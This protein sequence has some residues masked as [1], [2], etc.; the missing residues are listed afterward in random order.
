METFKPSDSYVRLATAC[1]EV[2]VAD[3]EANARAIADLYSQA[4]NQGAA[5]VVFPELSIT[6]YSL[7]DLVQQ[8]SLLQQAQLGLLDLAIKSKQTST[9]MVVGTPMRVGSGLYNCAVVIAEGELKG[10]VPKQN[11]PSYGEFYEKRWYKTWDQVTTTVTIGDKEVPFGTD[12]LFD[13]GAVRMGVEI[14]EDLW[15]LN[16]PHIDQVNNGALIIANPS[17]SPELVAKA[18]YRRDLVRID[19]AKMIGAYVYAGCDWTESTTDVVMSGHQI[20]AANG[21]IAAE[22]KPF[23]SENRVIVAD[24]DIDHLRHDR[25]RDTNFVNKLGGTVIRATVSQPEIEPEPDINPHPFLPGGE[26]DKQQAERLQSVID[27]QAHGL[28]RRIKQKSLRKLHLGLSGGLD[29]TLAFLVGVRAAQ[30]VGCEPKDVLQT[31]TMPGKAS[32]DRTQNNAVKLA[33]LYGISNEVIPIGDLSNQMLEAI[34]HTG[35]QDTTFENAQA[36]T[37]TTILYNKANQ[38]GGIVLGTGDLSEIALGWCT[39]NADQSS[40]YH[41]NAGVPKTLVRHLVQHVVTT[42]S[43]ESVKATLQDIVDTPVSPELVSANEGEISQKTEDIIGPYELHDFFMYQLI[44]WGDTPTKVEYLA[45]KAFEDTYTS[46]DISRWLKVFTKRFI[47]NQFKRSM[48]PDG[49]KVGSVALS[50][51]GDWRMPSDLYNAA[52]WEQA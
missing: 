49:V 5:L 9:A 2:F 1:P 48:M 40:H 14:C 35:E 37:R 28:A 44:R 51:R 24:I 27:I 3:V 26:T 36:R 46:E 6:G 19:S 10:I 23:E 43:S 7:G 50:P 15:A 52:V 21:R 30:I 16:S 29:S 8:N 38:L 12:L 41:V 13:I 20:I 39:F 17:A 11:L 33:K 4:A 47:F 34:K 45:N 22:R 31:Y 32:S 42:S 25:L 18:A